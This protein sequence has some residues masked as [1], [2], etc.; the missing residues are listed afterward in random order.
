MVRRYLDRYFYRVRLLPISLLPPS[1]LCLVFS[2]PLPARPLPGL[3][4]EKHLTHSAPTVATAL[5][6]QGTV[7]TF[8]NYQTSVNARVL[9]SAVASAD[10]SQGAAAPNIRSPGV[11]G[12]VAWGVVGLGAVLGAGM[13]L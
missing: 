12:V 4:C 5:V 13:V 11:G 9:A 8:A 6:P 7:Q 2:P 10:G 1:L 3:A